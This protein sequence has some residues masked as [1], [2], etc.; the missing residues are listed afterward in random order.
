[1]C[2]RVTPLNNGVPAAASID[3]TIGKSPG[4]NRTVR[5]GW[6]GKP[7]PDYSFNSDNLE[8]HIKTYE[9]TMQDGRIVDYVTCEL[10]KSVAHSF[11]NV[12]SNG[13][14]FALTITAI[15]N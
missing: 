6:T 14:G 12:I 2:Q 9:F 11:L 5:F 13:L 8:R 1:M 10:P 15:L 7:I 3:N 4:Y